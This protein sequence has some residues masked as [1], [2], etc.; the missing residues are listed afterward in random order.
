ML[1]TLTRRCG[2][3]DKI[4]TEKQI[5]MN[6]VHELQGHLQQAYKKIA[7]LHEQLEKCLA[8]KDSKNVAS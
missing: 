1:T 3:T 8:E 7:E 5:L 2:M 4:I 6:N